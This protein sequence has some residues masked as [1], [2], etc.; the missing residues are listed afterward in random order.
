MID[1]HHHVWDLSVR[2]QDWI[3]GP[4]MAVIRR[5]FAV[6]TTPVPSLVRP[7]GYDPGL[8]SWRDVSPPAMVA[9]VVTVRTFPATVMTGGASTSR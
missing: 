1:A 8:P 4:K 5:S 9:A 7:P 3:T 6:D 2:D